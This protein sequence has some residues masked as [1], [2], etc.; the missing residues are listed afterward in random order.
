MAQD[1]DAAYF[2]RLSADCRGV[3]KGMWDGAAA[4]SL[5]EMAAEYDALAD[6]AR[7]VLEKRQA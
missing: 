4:A 7:R 1:H 3:A 2:R 5:R 6:K